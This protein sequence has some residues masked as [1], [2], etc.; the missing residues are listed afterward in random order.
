MRKTNRIF[1]RL[2]TSWS[3]RHTFVLACFLFIEERVS[4]P[5]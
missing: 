3:R 1:E 5:V 4:G 2:F